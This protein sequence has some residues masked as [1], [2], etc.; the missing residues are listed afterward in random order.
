MLGLVQRSGLWFKSSILSLLVFSCQGKDPHPPN[1]DCEAGDCTS[2]G[3]NGSGLSPSGSAGSAGTGGEAGSV[4]L[5]VRVVTLSSENFSEGRASAPSASFTLQGPGADGSVVSEQGSSP[6]VL[7][8]LLVSADAWVAAVPSDQSD[9]LPGLL[10]INTAQTSSVRLPLARRSDL[11]QVG[12][13]LTDPLF[14][15]TSK[16][17]AILRCSLESDDSAVSGVTVAIQGPERI[18]YDSGGGY[19]DEED[20][21]TGGAGLALLL[22][23][24]AA[25]SSPQ[26]A[27]AVLGG[28]AQGQIRFPLQAGYATYVAV[29]LSV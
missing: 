20:L 27:T 23:T 7:P 21:G 19:S 5:E 29:L 4:D 28:T 26:F 1:A 13:V 8:G 18:V 3:V 11:E 10:G 14:L 12:L 24:E 25:S 9:L 2:S 6:I 16:A 22:N 15:D 17:H